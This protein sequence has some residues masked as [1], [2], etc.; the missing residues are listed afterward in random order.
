M[1]QVQSRVLFCTLPLGMTDPEFA[2]LLF[3]QSRHYHLD[4]SPQRLD[5]HKFRVEVLGRQGNVEALTQALT[6]H[7]SGWGGRVEI[8]H[9]V[10][11]GKPRGALH[12]SGA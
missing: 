1:Q 2:D 7:L 6:E 5:D 3:D 9:T 11:V 8:E 4:I 10:P 12:A